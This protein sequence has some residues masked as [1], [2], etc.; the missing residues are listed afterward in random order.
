MTSVYIGS[1]PNHIGKE[2]ILN[3]LKTSGFP[4]FRIKK[5]MPKVDK[6]FFIFIAPNKQAYNSLIARKFVH[7]KGVKLLPIPYMTGAKKQRQDMEI[8]SKRIHVSKLP[9]HITDAKLKRLFEKYGEVESAYISPK[10]RGIPYKFGFVTFEKIDS[11]EE[12][13][14]IGKI[15]YSGKMVAIKRFGQQYS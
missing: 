8:R 6:R 5:C 2:D 1:V 12:M 15:K 14:R 11:A 7:V 10:C 13:V 9:S 4:N 3:C